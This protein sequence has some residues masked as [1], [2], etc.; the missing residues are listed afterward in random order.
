MHEEETERETIPL[1]FRFG[2][3][4]A[5]NQPSTHSLFVDSIRG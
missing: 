2:G 1:R 5:A 4:L 3:F